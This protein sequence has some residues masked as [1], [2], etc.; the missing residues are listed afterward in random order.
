MAA[1]STNLHFHFIDAM[2]GLLKLE[3]EIIETYSALLKKLKNKRYQSKLKDFRED[4]LRHAKGF[5]YILEQLDESIPTKEHPHLSLNGA[6][7]NKLSDDKEIFKT[8]DQLS[9]S[10]NQAYEKANQFKPKSPMAGNVLKLALE[11][12]IRHRTW[13]QTASSYL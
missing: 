8:L 7:I 11:D 10:T 12:G 3:Y 4:H 2:K 13:L 1:I 6:V 5:T 9:Y